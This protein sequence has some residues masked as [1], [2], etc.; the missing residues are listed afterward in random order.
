[1]F[2]EFLLKS[3]E[4]TGVA[5]SID[6]QEIDKMMRETN[7]GVDLNKINEKNLEAFMKAYFARLTEM[8]RTAAGPNV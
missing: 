3:C 5:T 8:Y 1:M 6:E 2:I 7:P 4:F